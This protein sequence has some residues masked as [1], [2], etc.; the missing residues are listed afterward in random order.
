HARAHQ[1]LRPAKVSQVAHPD[2]PASELVLIG[3]P[4]AAAGRADL[5]PGFAG[6][7]EQLVE[8]EREVRAVRNIELVLGPDAP[9]TEGVELGEERLRIEHDP[10]ADQ[11]Y[12]ALDDPRGN[13]VEH[14]FPGA[15][16][17]R[18]AGVRPAL[19]AHDQIGGHTVST[20]TIFPLPSSPHWAPT[21]TTQWVFGPNM[22]PQQKT[23]RK[24]GVRVSSDG[25]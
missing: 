2:A 22:A 1:L 16:V 13:L 3:G 24:R 17:H 18:V 9:L 23:P 21:T 15:S 20:S 10:V 12:R 6:P 11:A 14:E 7:V 19:I 25:S 4:D 5:L 8:R